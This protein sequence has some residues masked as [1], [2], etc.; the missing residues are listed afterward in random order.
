V[1]G[2]AIPVLVWAG[3]LFVLFVGN[4][5]WDAKTVNAAEAAFAAVIIF[6]AAFALWLAR[7]ESIRRGPPPPH[8][9]VE[10]S[11]SMS[12]GAVLAGLG[13]GSILF[14]I[15]WA[16]FLFFFGIGL[17]VVGLG[18]LAIELRSE[19]ASRRAMLDRAGAPAPTPREEVRR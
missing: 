17:F 18:R 10:A 15:V 12:L 8:T 1:R 14:G 13:V 9:T 7:H 2:G 11:P 3:L 6:A 19:R 5:I 4:W 16:Q